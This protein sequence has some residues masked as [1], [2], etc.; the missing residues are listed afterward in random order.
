MHLSYL[1]SVSCVFTSWVFSGFRVRSGCSWM[2]VRRQVFFPSWVP[3]GYTSSPSVATVAS[4]CDPSFTDMARNIS[5]ITRAQLL[6]YVWLF[7]TPWTVAC[8]APLSMRFPRQEFWSRVPFHPPGDLP[9]PGMELLSPALMSRFFTIEPLG[10]PRSHIRPP[11]FWI[12]FPV[13]SPQCIKS[14]VPCAI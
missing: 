6:S 2:A 10:S 12:S 5:L 9:D 4:E 3:P 1:G 8:W 11:L 13:R 7:A 14:R